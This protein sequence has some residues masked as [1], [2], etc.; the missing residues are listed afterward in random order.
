MNKILKDI[1]SYKTIYFTNRVPL[2][3]SKNNS[4]N[5]S[6]TISNSLQNQNNNQK[7]IEKCKICNKTENLIK[8]QYCKSN[9]HSNCLHLNDN[10]SNF[11]C[12]NC[13]QKFLKVSEKVKSEKKIKNK[14]QK[15][16]KKE[17]FKSTNNKIGNKRKREKGKQKEKEIT[18]QK[19]KKN[20][21]EEK[22]K[23]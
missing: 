17:I 21:K 23:Y 8:C 19:N 20:K 9:Y 14:T 3:E 11:L 22:K 13:K 15:K 6:L 7:E 5:S 4:S 1:P 16:E 2:Y 12:S 18:K 10:T